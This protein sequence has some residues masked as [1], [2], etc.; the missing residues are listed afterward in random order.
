MNTC[1]SSAGTPLVS[2]VLVIAGTLAAPSALASSFTAIAQTE[3]EYNPIY[4]APD[5]ASTSAFHINATD[6]GQAVASAT[7]GP[8]GN[9]SVASQAS[10]SVSPQTDPPSRVSES[11]GSEAQ[12]YMT[13][14]G[15]YLT[16]PGTTIFANYQL[17]LTGY[18]DVCG[19]GGAGS[20]NSS[21]TM[22]YRVPASWI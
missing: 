14:D 7:G 21:A 18:F 16:G 6:V 20:I 5:G 8:G 13:I 12:A 3:S 19:T 17:Q 10:I 4:G 11:T 15:L 9:I 1:R 2:F 22:S